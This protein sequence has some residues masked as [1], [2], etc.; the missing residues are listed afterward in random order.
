V[1]SG[2]ILLTGSSGLLGHW[3]R[4]TIPSGLEIV[5]VVHR[6][7]LADVPTVMVDLRDAEAAREVVVNVKPSLILHAAYAKDRASIVDTTRH[8]AEAAADVDAEILFISTDAVFNGDGRTLG[9]EATPDP[10]WDYG[11]WKAEAEQV[12]FDHNL[13][14]SIVRLPLVV[15]VE[16]DDQVVARIRA[17][18]AT[19]QVTVWYCD[20]FR[21]PARAAE[22]A[23][24]IWRIAALDSRSRQGVWHLPGPEILSRGEIARRVVAALELDPR[25]IRL[26]STPQDAQRPRH[27][28]MLA[29]RAGGAIGWSPSPVFV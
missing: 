23:E 21:Q 6:H 13:A 1:Q 12:V 19:S 3:L 7:D 29:S 4:H 27:L 17:A 2:P 10:V 14:G 18:S 9:E 11:R 15:S 26:E 25:S 24:A 28:Q 20:E 22:L 5:S 16:P 8:L